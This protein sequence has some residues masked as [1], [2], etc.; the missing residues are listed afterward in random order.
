MLCQFPFP[1]LLDD[2]PDF[3]H[4]FDH[5]HM[6]FSQIVFGAIRMLRQKGII[7]CVK[8]VNRIQQTGKMIVEAAPPDE[9]VPVC[10]RFDFGPIDIQLFQR[11]K[12]FFFQTAHKLTV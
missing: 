9:R 1:I 7:L 3:V 5:E 6:G 2:L 12:P 10:V 11:D 4:S 8:G